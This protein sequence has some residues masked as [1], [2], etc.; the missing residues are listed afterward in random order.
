MN[1]IVKKPDNYAARYE[2]DP[3]AAF[4]TRAAPASRQAAPVQE[5]R[6]VDRAGRRPV[7]R[8]ALPLHRPEHDARVDEVAAAASSRRI[9]A[10]CR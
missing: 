8:G 6:V 9:W 4:A 7:A 1:D 10:P 5:G 2:A 3:Y